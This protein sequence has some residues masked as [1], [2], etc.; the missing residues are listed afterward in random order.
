[1]RGLLRRAGLETSL[2]VDLARDGDADALRRGFFNGEAFPRRMLA[3]VLRFV[4]TNILSNI[5]YSALL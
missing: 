4:G 2:S 1:M 3:K 5:S